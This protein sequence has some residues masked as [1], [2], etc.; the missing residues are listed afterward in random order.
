MASEKYIDLKLYYGW[1]SSG[2]LGEC[3]FNQPGLE[4]AAAL[5]VERIERY[6]QPEYQWGLHL[7]D[8]LYGNLVHTEK[9]AVTLIKFAK[10]HI[11]SAEGK[12]IPIQ[13]IHGAITFWRK[14][15]FMGLPP[16]R[17]DWLIEE[18]KKQDIYQYHGR[19][20]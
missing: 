2:D 4:R 16:N 3:R 7:G 12:V 10:A 17:S 8:P 13:S 18:M 19:H 11:P 9:Q 5:A 6:L 1:C 15:R 14:I 20:L